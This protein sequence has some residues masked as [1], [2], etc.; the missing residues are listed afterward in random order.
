V[1]LLASA[2]VAILHAL[3]TRAA[4]DAPVTL[5]ASPG[6]I[7]AHVLDL[8]GLPH[9]TDSEHTDEQAD[10]RAG[11]GGDSQRASVNWVSG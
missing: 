6:S 10:E 2:D 8:V 4:L 5:I 3:L 7:A 9:T 11:H 1:T